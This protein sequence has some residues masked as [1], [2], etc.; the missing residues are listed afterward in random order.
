MSDGAIHV[1]FGNMSDVAI[2]VG[3]KSM[4]DEVMKQFTWS[5]EYH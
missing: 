3:F 5:L 4:S 2:R 1:G